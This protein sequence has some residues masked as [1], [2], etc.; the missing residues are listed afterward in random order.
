MDDRDN[1]IESERIQ[2]CRDHYF[3]FLVDVTR[4]RLDFNFDKSSQTLLNEQQLNNNSDS[5]L[6]LKSH[7]RH[8]L[9]RHY[10]SDN[11]LIIIK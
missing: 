9:H 10:L 3:C 4:C 8:N 2:M 11:S 6:G 5:I 7:H 1:D